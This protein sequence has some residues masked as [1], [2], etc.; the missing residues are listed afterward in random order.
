MVVTG[1]IPIHLLAVERA[2][3]EAAL[4]TGATPENAKQEA[5]VRTMG[6]WQYQWNE[7]DNGRW[8]HQLIPKIQAWIDRKWGSIKYHLKQILTGYG[9]FNAY[10]LKYKKREDAVCMYCSH[11]HDDVEHIFVVCDRWWRQRHELE[12]KLGRAITSESMLDGMLEKRKKWDA[13]VNFINAVLS[14]KEADEQAIQ[15]A[16]RNAII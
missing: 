13:V 7:A 3:I 14:R 10:L 12:V 4:K 1:T 2:E 8:T 9:C 16:A 11:A 5:R 15:A 6:K